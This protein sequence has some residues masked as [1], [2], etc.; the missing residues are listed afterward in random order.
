MGNGYASPNSALIPV[1]KHTKNAEV[2]GSKR[3]RSSIPIKPKQR[4]ND[5]KIHIAI[6]FG[7]DGCALAYYYNNKVTVYNKCKTK[8]QT[9]ILLNYNFEVVGFCYIDKLIYSR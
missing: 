2:G 1:T 7:T 3:P 5:F 4:S 9:H 8:I 6:D